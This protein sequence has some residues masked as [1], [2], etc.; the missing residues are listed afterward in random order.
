MTGMSLY[1][2]DQK[3]SEV[4]IRE[5]SALQ[6]T[7][8]YAIGQEVALV[9]DVLYP[10]I[11]VDAQSN[12]WQKWV[13]T[14]DRS[15]KSVI[16]VLEEGA[17]VPSRDDFSLIDDVIQL[18][19]RM[20]DLASKWRAHQQRIQLHQLEEELRHSQ[21]A[22]GEASQLLEQIQK[23]HSPQRFSNLKGIRVQS[24]HL[25]GLKP[26]GDYFDIFES[27]RK[28]FLNILVADSSSYGLSSALLGAILSSSAKIANDAHMSP[29]Q[30][31]NAI[32]S[33]IKKT[34]SK[35]DELSL[36]FARLNRIDFSLHYTLCG[37]VE[38]FKMSQN[39]EIEWFEKTAGKISSQQENLQ[40]AEKV[41][42]LNPK[43]RILIVTD[44]FVHGLGG[45]ESLKQLLQQKKEQDAFHT[46]NELGF[47]IKSKLKEGETF[48]GEDC[49][50]MVI[51]VESRVLRLAP[52]GS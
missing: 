7:S 33:E 48:P 27:D 45:L 18:P 26:G 5:L 31:V 50:A 11:L 49:S 8:G 16:L 14:L 34:I 35:E 43:D 38:V 51:D 36:F 52:T 29:M 1:I 47:L 32:S 40:H 37:A 30:W 4:W 46:I 9:T 10:I 22:I 12:D 2:K 24:R 15:G 17:P 21:M 39:G 13:E 44:G 28:D 19:F 25:S 20:L 3:K 23:A 42:R 41:V 6:K